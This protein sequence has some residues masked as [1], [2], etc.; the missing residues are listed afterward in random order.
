MLNLLYKRIEI[1]NIDPAYLTVC[2][3]NALDIPLMDCS[4]D[5]TIA[6]SVLHLISAPEIVVKE[7]HRVLKKGGKFI[8]FDDKPG[9][10]G[11]NTEGDLTED[12]KEDNRPVS[13]LRKKPVVV[14]RR[15]E[16]D[17]N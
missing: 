15:N 8:T 17:A 5:A 14:E 4:V 13:K 10:G 2:R 12:E 1:A 16:F 6:N 9:R 7:I 3:A 11:D